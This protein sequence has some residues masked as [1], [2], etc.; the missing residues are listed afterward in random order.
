MKSTDKITNVSRISA[1]NMSETAESEIENNG[2][3]R[4]ISKKYIYLQE[5]SI[6]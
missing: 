2:I 6:N 1:K 3:D 5:I 4:E